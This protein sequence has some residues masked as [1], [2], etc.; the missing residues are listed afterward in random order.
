MKNNNINKRNKIINTAIS[1]FHLTYNVNK[2]SIQDIAVKANVSPTT[3]YNYFGTR[4]GLI[5][6]VI[7]S[8]VREN[9]DRNLTLVRSDLPFPQKIS[10]IISGKI[11]L[12]SAYN[13]EIIEKIVT[14]DRT[15]APLINEIY[16][17]EIKPLWLEVLLTGKKEGYIDSS[18]D[19]EALFIYMDALKTGLSSKQEL[20]RSAATNTS[21]LLQLTRIFFYGFLKKDIDFTPKEAK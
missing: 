20:M 1:L 21:L 11:D 4:D 13:S 18:L 14:Y 5:Y 2:V 10:S 9:M 12:M 3:I 8:L 15:I 17:K 7:K 6:E 19:N 16:E